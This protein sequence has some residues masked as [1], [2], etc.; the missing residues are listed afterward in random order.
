M[1][2]K[3][4]MNDSILQ[5][6]DRLPIS[7]TM[8][9]LSKQ[10]QIIAE[11]FVCSICLCIPL[12]AVSA[13]CPDRHIFCR[14]CL[15]KAYE[16]I[17]NNIYRCPYCNVNCNNNILNPIHY[18]EVL[19]ILPYVCPSIGCKTTVVIGKLYDHLLYYCDYIKV[20]CKYCNDEFIKKKIKIHE[21]ICPRRTIPCNRC[22]VQVPVKD[23]DVH[24]KTCVEFDVSCT[25]C[26]KILKRKELNDHISVCRSPQQCGTN[27]EH[28]ENR[29]RNNNNT[30]TNT[31]IHTPRI[32][33]K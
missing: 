18:I 15:T 26:G 2:N 33:N 28:K 1:E 19:K 12:D 11:K 5:N 31:L 22:N 25:I 7:V 29:N 16:Y 20:D 21:S 6:N 27:K 4:K 23:I 13:S 10:N 32:Y 30:D 17:P 3:N 8:D 14:C 9:G 24:D